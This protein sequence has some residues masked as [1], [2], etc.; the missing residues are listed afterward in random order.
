MQRGNE[1]KH[2]GARKQGAGRSA[3]KSIF[4]QFFKDYSTPKYIIPT[5]VN[6]IPPQT[7]KSI[8]IKTLV[9][10]RDSG[11]ASNCLLQVAR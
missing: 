3:S 11:D 5:L 2:T 7:S 4:S 8:N 1:Y 6:L 10:M 9:I